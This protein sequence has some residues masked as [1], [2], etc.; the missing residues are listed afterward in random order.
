M[1]MISPNQGHSLRA[2]PPLFP[3]T[4]SP[5]SPGRGPPIPAPTP[6]P[7][8]PLASHHSSLA[9]FSLPRSPAPPFFF[10]LSCG[11]APPWP[12]APS[13]RPSTSA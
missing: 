7:L 2:C 8:L 3:A 11:Q 12:L 4:Q 1:S 13:A 9:R 5:P 6:T 10:L